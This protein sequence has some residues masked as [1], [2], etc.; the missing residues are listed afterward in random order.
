MILDI[1][2]T[3]TSPILEESKRILKESCMQEHLYRHFSSPG[4]RGFINGVSVTLIH[5][6]HG[7][8]SKKREI[9]WMKIVKSMAPYG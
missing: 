6:T 7:S 8:D 4:H 9:Y 1:D 2:G 3:I 5:K